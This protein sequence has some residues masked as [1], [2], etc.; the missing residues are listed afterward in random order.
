MAEK[1]GFTHMLEYET[2]FSREWIYNDNFKLSYQFLTQLNH[3][4]FR[5]RE[6]IHINS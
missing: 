3:V 2:L 1:Q 4:R 6:K 5:A